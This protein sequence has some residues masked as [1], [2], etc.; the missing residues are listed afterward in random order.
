M[1]RIAGCRIIVVITI[2]VMTSGCG[3]QRT[4]DSLYAEARATQDWSKV[5]LREAREAAERARAMCHRN[6]GKLYCENRD[7]RCVSSSTVRRI[8]QPTFPDAAFRTQPNR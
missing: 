6:K 4:L 2:L 3:S 8:M 1:G 5:D 7:C